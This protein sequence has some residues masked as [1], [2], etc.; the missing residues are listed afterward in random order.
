ME[1]SQTHALEE[2]PTS[3]KLED[4]IELNIIEG[5]REPCVHNLRLARTHSFVMSLLLISGSYIFCSYTSA[6]G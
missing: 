3:L 1:S 2:K 5:S 6:D 4:R